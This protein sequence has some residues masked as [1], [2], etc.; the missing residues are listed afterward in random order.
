M[1]RVK[2]NTTALVQTGGTQFNPDKTAV[3]KAEVK[4]TYL[5]KGQA[6]LEV[7][8]TAK[9]PNW[10]EKRLVSEAVDA[11]EPD[12]ENGIDAQPAK[13]AVWDECKEKE[14]INYGWYPFGTFD[15]VVFEADAEDANLTRLC[16]EQAVKLLGSEWEIA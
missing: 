9:N 16:E 2:N 12:E 3:F 11:V 15:C 5:G 13:E 4:P 6:S 10:Y 1:I 7:L 14:T 8:F